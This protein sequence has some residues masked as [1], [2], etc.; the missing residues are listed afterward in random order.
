M[1]FLKAIN[2]YLKYYTVYLNKNNKL[3]CY[4]A[5]VIRDMKMDDKLMRPKS[6]ELNNPLCKLKL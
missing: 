6:C 3:K 4:Y 2:E 1:M 5:D